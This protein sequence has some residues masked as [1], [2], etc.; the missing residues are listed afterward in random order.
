MTPL[1]WALQIL[2]LALLGAAIPFALRLER[3]LAALRQDRAALDAGAQGLQEATRVA[4][5]ALVRLRASAELSGRQISEKTAAAEPVRDDLRFLIERAEGIADRLEALVRM[6]RPL[7]AEAPPRAAAPAAPAP[8]PAAAAA[9]E[10]AR[11]GRS[12]AEL[13]LMRALR[14]AR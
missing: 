13:D 8:A 2:L 3:A 1:E 11:A 6:A 10:P 12:Q 4:E 7:A 14:L 9:E 5:A